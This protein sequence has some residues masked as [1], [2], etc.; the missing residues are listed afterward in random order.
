M[1]PA[2][3]ERFVIPPP[4]GLQFGLPP[5]RTQPMPVD[6]HANPPQRS[7]RVTGLAPAAASELSR[8]VEP[9]LPAE[10][11]ASVAPNPPPASQVRRGGDGPSLESTRRRP[12]PERPKQPAAG[13]AET[14]ARPSPG[15]N[16]TARSPHLSE[17][18]SQRAPSARPVVVEPTTARHASAPA[19][20][21]DGKRDQVAGPPG[22]SES[23]RPA[24]EPARR[25]RGVKR[26]TTPAETGSTQLTPVRSRG[27]FES[28]SQAEQ[29]SAGPI[30]I[31][32]ATAPAGARDGKRDQVTGSLVVSQFASPAVEP[33]RPRP[34]V[35]RTTTPAETGST[36]LTPARSRGEFE[37]QD[38]AEQ[39]IIR[40][41]AVEPTAA[42]SPSL[43]TEAPSPA[44]APS[45]GPSA[46]RTAVA[47]PLVTPGIRPYSPPASPRLAAPW[48]T[49]EP[50]PTV[51]VT[52][53]RVEV[54][55]TPPPV[56]PAKKEG[57]RPPVM[58]LEEYLRQRNQGGHR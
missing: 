1:A 27:E 40:E 58:S 33:A 23:A 32:P 19:D 12:G 36:Q 25:R 31:E 49:P 24:V 16:E 44:D 22:V 42:I 3:I 41:V 35:K 11:R 14:P 15:G 47:R 6:S 21:R 46:P 13:N 8:E 30:V 48:G 57:S 10:A 28:Q 55:A 29:P 38:Q 52:I 53:G 56:A 2:P 39:P 43:L 9:T 26:T 34:W 50:T 45:P 5:S 51:N 54:R 17:P 37:S 7:R 4:P 20:A 18:R